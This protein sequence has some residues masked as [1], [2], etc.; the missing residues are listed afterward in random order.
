LLAGPPE[1]KT[2]L[3]YGY[4][5]TLTQ[6]LDFCNGLSNFPKKM[7]HNCRRL[8]QWPGMV[9]P[10]PAKPMTTST[11]LRWLNLFQLKEGT[12]PIF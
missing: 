7:Y 9:P 3:N 11:Q 6:S 5:F 1:D 4:R 10:S 12:M 2:T 8:R